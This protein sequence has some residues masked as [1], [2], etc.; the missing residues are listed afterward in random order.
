MVTCHQ[1]GPSGPGSSAHQ[2]PFAFLPTSSVPAQ[3][4]KGPPF[5][6]GRLC[7]A[8]DEQAAEASE[9]STLSPSE[10]APR[11]PGLP[12]RSP[13]LPLD[14][15]LPWAAPVPSARH[16]CLPAWSALVCLHLAAACPPVRTHSGGS[17]WCGAF[18]KGPGPAP[19]GLRPEHGVKQS[20]GVRQCLLNE[21]MNGI[22]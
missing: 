16:C 14:P 10:A 7:P 1:L 22:L 20:K 5:P 2:W 11:L 12:V 9:C 13:A 8:G 4:R 17:V 18:E 15:S 6:E 21:S 3:L 19:L